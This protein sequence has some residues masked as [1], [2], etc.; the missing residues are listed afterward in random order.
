MILRY[1][2]DMQPSIITNDNATIASVNIKYDFK[3]LPLEKKKN[4]NYAVVGQGW[5]AAQAGDPAYRILMVDPPL[6]SQRVLNFGYDVPCGSVRWL[7]RCVKSG[8]RD[9]GPHK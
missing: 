4:S 7:L 2:L 9:D 8:T 3:R 1:K 5:P 6:K